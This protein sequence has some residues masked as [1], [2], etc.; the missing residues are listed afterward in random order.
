MDPLSVSASVVGILAAAGKMAPLLTKLTALADAPS[1]AVATLN[2][3]SEMTAALRRFQDYLN[4]TISVPAGCEQY[5][6]LEHVAATLIG[7][8]TT[9]S[10]LEAIIDS[11]RVDPETG[12]FDR[13]R[14]TDKENDIRDIVQRIQNHRTSLT[15]MLT[16]LQW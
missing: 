10:E 6:L 5:V 7:S 11:V 16:I 4:G 14:W 2:E 1:S 13:I 15:L 9:Y 12:T 3:I 8:V